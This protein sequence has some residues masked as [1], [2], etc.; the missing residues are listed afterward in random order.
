MATNIES[1]I[2]AVYDE[3]E[4]VRSY[5][6]RQQALYEAAADDC[7]RRES[8]AR[9]STAA[10]IEELAATLPQDDQ[11]ND[12]TTS[13]LSDFEEMLV[14]L[15]ELRME[16]EESKARIAASEAEL[17]TLEQHMSASS[18]QVGSLL[19]EVTRLRQSVA[20]REVSCCS[21]GQRPFI[22]AR[23]WARAEGARGGAG[24]AAGGARGCARFA[25]RSCCPR[26]PGRRRRLGCR[27]CA[28][29][30][31]GAWGGC[32]RPLEIG[33]ADSL[34]MPLSHARCAAST[35]AASFSRHLPTRPPRAASTARSN[36]SHTR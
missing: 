2:Y 24:A 31:G 15:N 34:W 9:T 4:R 22:T 23:E 32:Q 27:D 25:E 29:A 36:G 17:K 6:S 14:E 26:D 21:Y 18:A 5:R 10:R 20:A 19:S 16:E 33:W 13:A 7:F 35:R 11:V 28:G 1:E 30:A 3:R 12:V 8:T